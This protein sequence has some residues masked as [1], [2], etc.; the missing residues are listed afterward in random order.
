MSRKEG[1]SIK[2]SVDTSIRRLE[3]YIKK[4]KER[5]IAATKN[6]TNRTRINRTTISQ[7]QKWEEKQLHGYFKQ[8][9]SEILYETT[10]TWLRK[11]NLKKET[12]SPLVATQNNTIRTNYSKA[13]IDKI[14]ESFKCKLC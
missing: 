10:W 3:D 13:K 6:N 11:G 1:G 5:L 14:Q 7:K 12:E 8:Q 9:T 4:S 2:D